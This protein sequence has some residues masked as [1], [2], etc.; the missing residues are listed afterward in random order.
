VI[1]AAFFISGVLAATCAIF[2]VALDGVA[3]PTTG[4]S[5]V[6]IG[7]IAAVLGG[8]GSLRGAVLA[9]YII[10]TLT[11]LL[12][13]YLPASMVAY[14]DAFVYSVILAMFIVRPSG[15]WPT[16]LSGDRV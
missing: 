16:P 15:L 13:R 6:I 8:L 3:T 14:R 12:Q 5:L 7:F 2:L 9:G 10:G 1:P 4:S 11:V